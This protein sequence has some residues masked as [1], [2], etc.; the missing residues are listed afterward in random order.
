MSEAAVCFVPGCDILQCA[1]NKIL[2]FQSCWVFGVGWHPSGDAK[3]THGLKTEQTSTVM[4]LPYSV[5]F[6]TVFNGPVLNAQGDPSVPVW[7]SLYLCTQP[8]GPGITFPHTP[9]GITAVTV[10]Y[11]HWGEVPYTL[12]TLVLP[13]KQRTGWTWAPGSRQFRMKC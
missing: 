9:E 2:R 6:L 7:W 4:Q 1:F 8:G 3:G 11:W 13:W 12:M 5:F 10:P